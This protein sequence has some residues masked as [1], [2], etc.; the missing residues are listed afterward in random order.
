MKI[1]GAFGL[2]VFCMTIAGCGTSGAA[3]GEK[4]AVSISG[5]SSGSEANAGADPTVSSAVKYAVR[6]VRP[7]V[8][9]RTPMGNFVVQLEPESAP[10]TVENFLKHVEEGYYNGTIF[11]SVLRD[12]VIIGGGYAPDRREKKSAHPPVKH[13]ARTCKLKN[14]RDTIAMYRKPDVVDSANTQFFINVGDNPHLDYQD[15][16]PQNCGYCVFGRVIQGSD[17]LHRIAQTPV[18]DVRGFERIPK[19]SVVITTVSILPDTA[20]DSP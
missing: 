2:A 19:Q 3:D 7:M 20:A 12:R 4:A 1:C 18:E 10:L 15:D 9:F 16:S 6:G 17:V 11:H 8:Q 14:R 13:E 5:N